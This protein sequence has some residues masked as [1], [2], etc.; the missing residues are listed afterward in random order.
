MER[1]IIFRGDLD[2]VIAT[3]LAA[4]ERGEKV[5]GDFNGHI[6]HSDTASV[7]SIYLEVTGYTKEEF[8]K[9]KKEWMEEYS[10]KRE[11]EQQKALENIPNW[12]QMGKTIIFPERHDDW[13]RCVQIRAKDL[14]CGLELDASLRIMQALENG[15][16]VEEAAK[17]LE[18][19]SGLA[20]D[21]IRRIVFD[22]SSKGPEF[23]EGTVRG[24]MTPEDM[25]KI[26]EKKQENIQ[27]AQANAQK[28]EEGNKIHM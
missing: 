18:G 16:S 7:D 19:Q 9:K 15:V 11:N 27:L 13:E 17:M 26:E 2:K 4:K 10:K 23:W 25:L 3:L 22:F 28:A 6:L 5:W 1:Q 8:E 12:I 21:L 20:T 24:D 14:F